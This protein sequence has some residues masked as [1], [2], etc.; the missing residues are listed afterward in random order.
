MTRRARNH[1]QQQ[2]QQAGG[3]RAES[4]AGSESSRPRRKA[5]PCGRIVPPES[6][7]FDH[8]RGTGNSASRARSRSSPERLPLQEEA[9]SVTVPRMPRA[10]GA[11]ACD[12][13]A[14]GSSRCSPEEAIG[15]A[16]PARVGRSRHVA[17]DRFRVGPLRRGP[18]G[19]CPAPAARLLPAGP[20]APQVVALQATLRLQLPVAQSARDGDRVPRLGQRRARARS[21]RAP[22]EPGARHPGRAKP[23]RRQHSRPALLRARRRGWPG[24]RLPGRGRRTGDGRLLA[25]GRDDRRDHPVRPRRQALRRAHRRPAERQPLDRRLADAPAARPEPDGRL[26]PLPPPPR[27]S[28]RSSTSPR[29]SARRSRV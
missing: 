4:S 29:S 20:P 16:C 27:S 23:L 5:R 24:D 13:A 21:G 9:A 26:A 8:L 12:A 11:R 3:R 7:R 19:R 22:G 2:E 14:G 28:A 25:G 15:G 6:Y 10:S 17:P 18:N 1:P